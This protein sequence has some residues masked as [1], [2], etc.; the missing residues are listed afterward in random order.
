MNVPDNTQDAPQNRAP[1]TTPSA[2]RLIPRYLAAMVPVY[3]CRLLPTRHCPASY[4]GLCGDEFDRPC[5]RY[6]SDDETPWLPE[7]D[8]N[9][10]ARIV[11]PRSQCALL[12]ATS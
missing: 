1:D 6:E 7:L 12:R 3:P 8:A 11:C 10:R 5:A 4:R 9:P 2:E